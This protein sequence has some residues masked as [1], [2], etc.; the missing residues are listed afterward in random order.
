MSKLDELSAKIDAFEA[1]IDAFNARADASAT[2]PDSFIAKVVGTSKWVKAE[3]WLPRL[4]GKYDRIIP[5]K[6]WYGIQRK[7]ARENSK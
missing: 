4:R 2:A 3:Q 7:W 1:R 6:E 5:Q